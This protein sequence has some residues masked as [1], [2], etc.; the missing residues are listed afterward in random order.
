MFTSEHCQVGDTLWVEFKIE[1]NEHTKPVKQKVCPLTPSHKENLKFQLDDWLRD[2][3]I[4]P[5]DSRF[6][7]GITRLEKRSKCI[8][9]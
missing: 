4:E 9:I 6:P 3:V 2:S 1:L 8:C 7:M 5:A